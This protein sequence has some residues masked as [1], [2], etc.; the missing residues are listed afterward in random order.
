MLGL[1]ALPRRINFERDPRQ[2]REDLARTFLRRASHST[3]TKTQWSPPA[4]STQRTTTHTNPKPSSALTISTDTQ[5]A[6]RRFKITPLEKSVKKR[7]RNAILKMWMGRRKILEDRALAPEAME[8][9]ERLESLAQGSGALLWRNQKNHPIKL[10]KPTI[11]YN[12]K[13]LQ[14]WLDLEEWIDTQLQKLYQFQ[15]LEEMEVT[16]APE[17]ETD[18][19]ELLDVTNEDLP[20]LRPSSMDS[21]VAP[22]SPCYP[23]KNPVSQQH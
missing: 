7:C 12:Q 11:R 5:A 19:E 17:T 3:H 18:S 1:A 4:V 13:D 9:V 2:G 15:L 20:L 22:S 8:E 23:H 10:S 14:R 16:A 6:R 21:R